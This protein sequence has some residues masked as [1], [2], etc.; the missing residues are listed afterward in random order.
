MQL[1]TDAV[2]RQEPSGRRPLVLKIVRVTGAAYSGNPMD[3]FLCAPLFAH[4]LL[5]QWT[6]AIQTESEA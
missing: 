4:P 5:V 1:R 3:D 2:R 6:C